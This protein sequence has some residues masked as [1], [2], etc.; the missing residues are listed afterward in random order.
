MWLVIG[1]SL[2]L[3]GPGPRQGAEE[4]VPRGPV[5]TGSGWSILLIT[6]DTLRPDHLGAY[7][8]DRPT[9]P[10]IDALAEEGTLFQ[11]AFTYWPKTRGSFV[12]MLPDLPKGHRSATQT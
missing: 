6:I 12:A 7:G 4:P 8:Y 1:A 9:S 10:N 2:V 3:G 11:Q 5:G